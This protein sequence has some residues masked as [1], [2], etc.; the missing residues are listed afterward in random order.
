LAWQLRIAASGNLATPDEKPGFGG[1]L[2]CNRHE[3]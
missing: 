1:L 3:D 2:V